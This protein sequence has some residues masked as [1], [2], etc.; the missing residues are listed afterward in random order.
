MKEL[1]EG[2]SMSKS[3]IEGLKDIFAINE[4]TEGTR[5]HLQNKIDHLNALIAK[6]NAAAH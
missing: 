4:A 2:L 1:V 6:A 5:A 3:E